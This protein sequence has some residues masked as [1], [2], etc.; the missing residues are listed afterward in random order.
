MNSIVKVLQPYG[1]LNRS[2]SN[3]LR[4]EVQ[5]IMTDKTDIVLLDLSN[6]SFIDSSGLGAL[7]SVMKVVR[8]G[9]AKFYICS[10][11]DQVRMLFELTKMD[12]IFEH[13]T[14]REEFTRQVL[15]T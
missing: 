11:N 8:S 13:F 7:I 14:D 5:D 6:V 1:I 4:R 10:M 12:R 9:N 15:T 3:E 2:S